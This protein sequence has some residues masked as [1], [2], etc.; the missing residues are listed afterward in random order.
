MNMVFVKIRFCIFSG[1]EFS[2]YRDC[3]MNIV[4]HSIAKVS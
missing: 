1:Y 4:G 2:A 3:S